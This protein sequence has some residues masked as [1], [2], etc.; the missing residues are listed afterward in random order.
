MGHQQPTA[1]ISSDRKNLICRSPG[2]TVAWVRPGP[3]ASDWLRL[4]KHNINGLDDGEFQ[5]FDKVAHDVIR[6]V[7]APKRRLEFVITYAVAT[8]EIIGIN[9]AR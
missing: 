8:G 4:G 9:D 3:S 6:V 5:W 2:G 7:F 1:E